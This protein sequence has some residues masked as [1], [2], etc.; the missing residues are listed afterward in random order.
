MNLYKVIYSI[1]VFT[2]LFPIFRNDFYIAQQTDTKNIIVGYSKNIFRGFNV[3]DAK[4]AASLIENAI[5]RENRRKTVRTSIVVN[6]VDDVIELV[7]T[8]KLDFVSLTSI[9]YLA[10]KD[11]TKIYPYCAPIARDNIMNRVLLI[12]RNDSNIKLIDDLKG[13]SISTSSFYDEEYKLPT[14]WMKTIFWRSKIKDINKFI[15]SLKVRDNPSIIISD[16]FFKTT[17]AC[18]IYE[19]EF[20]TLKELNPQLGKQLK[21]LLSSEPLLTEVG[22]Y[23]ENSKD[24]PDMNFVLETTYNLHKNTHGKNLLKLLKIKKLLPYK[25]ELIKN[26]DTLYR[27]FVLLKKKFN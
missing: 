6:N 1:A 12:V 9:E 17:D 2:F 3:N 13:K 22:C 5:S 11:R 24:D 14:M 23:T 4:V 26:A 25:T 20:E 21:V 18:I 16:V 8:N 19:S 10:V 15:G 7:K 27:E